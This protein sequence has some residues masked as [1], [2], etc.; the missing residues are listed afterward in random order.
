M[1][2]CFFLSKKT[3]LSSRI[4]FISDEFWVLTQFIGFLVVMDW[5]KKVFMVLTRCFGSKIG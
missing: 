4:I 2:M 1:F 3:Y 5:L